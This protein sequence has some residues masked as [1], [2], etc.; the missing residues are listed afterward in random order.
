MYA[1]SASR[2]FAV[3]AVLVATLAGSIVAGIERGGAE[4]AAPTRAQPAAQAQG[5]LPMLPEVVV[6]ATRLEDR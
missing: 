6:T 5:Q 2:Q 4:F 3:A 1:Q